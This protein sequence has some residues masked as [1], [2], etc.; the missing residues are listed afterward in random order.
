MTAIVS[1]LLTAGGSE[2]ALGWILPTALN[3][4]LFGLLVLPAWRHVPALHDAAVASNPAKALALFVAAVVVGLV[5]SALQ[6]P[7]YRVL[8][9]YKWPA[10]IR[11]RGVVRQ[12]ER[13]LALQAQLTM[14]R[15]VRRKD[16]GQLNPEQAE[17][18]RSFWPDV[19]ARQRR[20]VQEWQ[21]SVL[22]ERLRRYPIDDEQILPSMLGNAIRRFEEYGYDRYRLDIVTMWYALTSAVPDQLRKQAVGSRAGVDFYICLIYGH[23]IV[24]VAAAVT[25]GLTTLSPAGPAAALAATLL[26]PALWYRLA[27]AAT[28]EWAAAIRALVDA[29]RRPLAESL[30]YRLP[31]TLNEER[32]IWEA[33]SRNSRAK[34]SA[35]SKA[36]DDFRLLLSRNR[37]S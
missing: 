15:L 2:L 36:A 17:R 12:K 37:D 8:E 5:L 4:A 22:A 6:T 27:V 23:L 24:A 3:W 34:Y 30:G 32:T 20:P 13:K 18:L 14:T 31:A 19:R 7:L 10:R 29:G 25:L 33:V 1:S 35:R 9:G 26:L 21:I 28:D 11:Q 16:L